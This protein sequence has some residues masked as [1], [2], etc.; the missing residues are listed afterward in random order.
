MRPSV[1]QVG[2]T[3][4]WVI[5]TRNPD[6]MVLKDADSDPTVAVRKNGV[7]VGDSVTVTKRAATTGIYDCSYNP[8]AEVEG[9]SFTLEETA[10]VTGTTTGSATYRASFVARVVAVERGTDS[11][12]TIAPAT[13]TNVSDVQTAV[14]AKLPAALTANGNMK[15]SLLEIITTALTEGAVGRMAAAFQGFWNVSAPTGTVNSLPSAVPGNASGLPRVSDVPT[16]AQMEAA[17]LNEG[18]ATALLAAIAA[19]VETFLINDGDATATLAAIA[20]ACNAAV[21]AGTVGTNAA[22]AATQATAAVAAI[23]GVQ[24]DTD[25]I[26]TRLPAAL[27]SG[28]MAA[29]LDSAARVKLDAIQSDYAPALEPELRGGLTLAEALDLMLASGVGV[30]SQPSGTTEKFKFVD[31]VDAFTTTFDVAGNRVSVVL[32]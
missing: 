32:H 10:T 1:F 26:K 2:G 22:T 11:A 5:Q 4:Y 20:T 13:P 15:S 21:A 29:E 19:K 7:A 12:N 3:L 8:A 9:D 17:I 28:R 16:T 23:A 24:S 30:S 31:A 14:L 27:V 25:N 18:D 6:T